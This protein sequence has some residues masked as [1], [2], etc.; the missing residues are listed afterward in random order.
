MTQKRKKVRRIY[1]EGENTKHDKRDVITVVSSL[2]KVGR[3]K[4]GLQFGSF[5]W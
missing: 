5:C 3:K 2:G 4:D 1:I